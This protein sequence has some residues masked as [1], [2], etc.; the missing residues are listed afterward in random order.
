MVSG[1]LASKWVALI[2]VVLV[3]SSIAFYHLAPNPSPAASSPIRPGGMQIR[4]SY[5]KLP[6]SFEANQG[7]TDPQVRFLARGLGYSLFLTSSEA[8][9]SLARAQGSDGNAAVLRMKFIGANPRSEVR[10]LEALPAKS[11][12]LQGGDPSR[13]RTGVPHY[14]RV[15]YTNIYP[16]IDMVYYGKQGELE[17][18]FVLAPGAS[19]SRINLEFEGV[20]KLKIDSGG[21]LVLRTPAGEVLQKRP[22]LY[23]V[24]Q[25]IRKE[26]SGRYI[27]KRKHHVGFEVESHDPSL[28]LVIDPVLAYSTYLGAATGDAGQGI[29][30]DAS[31]S[32]YITGYTSSVAFPTLNPFQ[33]SYAGG[34]CVFSF[35]PC[36]DAFVTKLNAAGTELV[37]STYLGGSLDDF[38]KS[39]AVDAAG[40]AYVTGDTSSTNFPTTQSAYQTAYAGGR[41]AFVAK[42]NVTGSAL[43]YSTYLGGTALDQANGIAL[44]PAGAACVIG[45]TT[46]NDFPTASPFQGVNA[47]NTDAFITYLN[48]SGSALL[49]SSFLGG[50]NQ[51]TAY[52]IAVNSSGDVYVAGSTSSGN[53]PTANAFQTINGGATDAFVT[54][55]NSI[56]SVL[57]YST[58]LGG[59]AYD[60]AKGIAIDVSGNAYVTGD[61]QS[62][63]FPTAVPF[64][65]TYGGGLCGPP[66]FSFSCRDAFVTK[67]SSTGAALVYSTYLGGAGY[68]N[69]DL[70]SAIAVDSTGVAYV[71]G[72]T[73]STDFPTLNA[74]QA[75]HGGQGAGDAFVTKFAQGGSSLLYSTY[76]GGSGDDWGSSIAVGAP[77]NV[78]LTGYTN[79][80]NFPIATP[81]DGTYGSIRDAFVS[82]IADI[83]QIT[84]DIQMS[85]TTYF[86]GNIVTASE[87]RLKN[88]TAQ[89]E[90]VEVKVWL[91]IPGMSPISILNLG[92]D[93]T[94]VVAANFDQ[95]FGPITL[96][97][98]GLEMPSGT[99][100]FSSRMVDPFTGKLISEDPTTFVKP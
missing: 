35:I 76:L 32:A 81:F 53:F 58:Y 62:P 66:E 85:Q 11:N 45:S 23:Q 77:G 68:S 13:W 42:L 78:Y 43:V 12:Y 94:F 69:D 36:G 89:N 39:I 98:M 50:S 48:A 65:G 3:S 34:S 37:Y 28:P 87:F 44:G 92:S 5:G 63:N 60:Q 55:F 47:G 8:V 41:D 18:D 91:R 15:R 1:R 71:T 14:A 97:Q 64:D 90:K 67:L 25:G 95:N 27:L 59:V 29:A 40:N 16:G 24:V 6:L 51:D 38:G 57:V 4:E 56:G 79:S 61:T 9:L 52:G 20:S 96:F 31:G 21:N 49:S 84:L 2:T 100:E 99:Y 70:G 93:G 30:V 10:G 7:Q 75:I 80:A 33:A 46:S 88:E 83:P 17:Y 72:N 74:I 22:L 26:I 54:K 73:R 82:K 19:P 86:N